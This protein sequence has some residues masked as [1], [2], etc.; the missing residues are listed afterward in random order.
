MEK[1]S[2]DEKFRKKFLTDTDSSGR[3]IVKSIK[4]GRT[5]YVEPIDDG[6]RS[7][8]G[9]LNPATKKIEGD[10]GSR[11]KGSVKRSESLISTENGF[12]KVTELK[13]GESAT[14]YINRI[15]DEYY[16]ATKNRK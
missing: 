6:N 4:T 11:Y 14:D 8:W 10:Y 2:I 3:F 9:D 15:D 12:D 1:M 13:P 16:N 5:Y 7:E